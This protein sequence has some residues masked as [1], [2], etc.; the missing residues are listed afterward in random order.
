MTQVGQRHI[1]YINVPFTKYYTHRISY[2]YVVH[3]Q[4][5]DIKYPT[6]FPK[7]LIYPTPTWPVSLVEV[8]PS[9][10]LSRIKPGNWAHFQT[11]YVG[12]LSFWFKSPIPPDT[13]M[14]QF[15]NGIM[16]LT[17]RI[18]YALRIQAKLQR[19]CALNRQPWLPLFGR[20]PIINDGLQYSPSWR[21]RN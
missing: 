14:V 5:F 8:S 1:F 16:T 9:I 20:Q 6:A 2:S 21:S 17:D 3:I 11:D 12:L 15:S 19:M 7:I 10:S 4:K 18:T 13:S